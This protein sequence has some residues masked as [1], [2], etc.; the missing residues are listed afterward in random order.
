LV[1]E[2]VLAKS[3]Y[4]EDKKEFDVYHKK[5]NRPLFK[6]YTI[7]KGV[8]SYTPEPP[9]LLSY[10]VLFIFLGMI[11]SLTLSWLIDEWQ[12]AKASISNK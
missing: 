4:K 10:L 7:E 2:Y 5:M 1:E 8:P 9:G 11:I 6:N 12:K 3:I